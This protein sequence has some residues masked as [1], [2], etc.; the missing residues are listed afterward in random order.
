MNKSLAL[1]IGLVVVA[2]GVVG[3]FTLGKDDAAVTQVGTSVTG[4]TFNTA[5]T[6]MIVWAPT[7]AAGTST[8]ILNSDANDRIVK[9]TQFFCS[10]LTNAFAQT[11]AG[12]ASLQFT[13]ATTATANPAAITNANTLLTAAVVATSSPALFVASTSP[14]VTGTAGKDFARVWA[15]NSYLSV[16]AN[17]TSSTQGCIIGVDYSAT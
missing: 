13:M 12:V 1:L 2:A 7:T 9:Q 6:A 4:N 15:A 5:K 11:S 16:T 3:Y 10:G 8:S 14:G 17:A